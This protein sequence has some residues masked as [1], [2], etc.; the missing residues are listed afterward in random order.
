MF[1]AAQSRGADHVY[2]ML[3]GIQC[4]FEERYANLYDMRAYLASQCRGV[5]VLGLGCEN[6][7]I[8]WIREMLGDIDED[9]VKFLKC[10]DYEDEI[11][12][13]LTLIEELIAVAQNDEREAIP[14]SELIVGLKCGGSDGLSGITA[15]LLLAP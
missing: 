14:A 6:N 2:G 13:A 12:A 1:Q 7:A 9:R 10:Q 3:N 8:A 15:T 5:L 4:M 11:S